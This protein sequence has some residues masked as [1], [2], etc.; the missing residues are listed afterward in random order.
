MYVYVCIYIYI[1]ICIEREICVCREREREEDLRGTKGVPKKGFWTSV[2]TSVWACKE[3][4][5]KRNQTS[6]YLRPPFL[7]TPLIPSRA[8]I[9]KRHTICDAK[10]RRSCPLWAVPLP[11]GGPLGILGV[12]AWEAAATAQVP[13]R[14][15]RF[16][17]ATGE[18]RRI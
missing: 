13:P 18:E 16:V 15:R 9:R 7:G 4:R 17:C 3:L 6:C 2:N 1:C 11:L 14:L 10:P 8:S 5:V 12:A